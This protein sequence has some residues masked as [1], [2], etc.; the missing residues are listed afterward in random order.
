MNSSIKNKLVLSL[1]V[2]A[3]FAA[4]FCVY[5]NILTQTLVWDDHY[6]VKKFSLRFNSLESLFLPAD[7]KGAIM[8]FYRPVAGLSYL[9]DYSLWHENYIGYHLTNV[10]LHILNCLLLFTLCLRTNAPKK[11]AFGA[12]MLFALHPIHTESVSWISAR[13]DLIA[14]AFIFLAL[15]CHIEYLRGDK[16][17][18]IPASLFFAFAL[19]SKEI[20]L[21]GVIVFALYELLVEKKKLGILPYIF[22]GIVVITYFIMRHSYLV[23]SSVKLVFK[24][25][26]DMLVL[27]FAATGFYFYKFIFP[28]NLSIYIDSIPYI[29]IFFGLGGGLFIFTAILYMKEK[30]IYAFLMASFILTLMPSVAGSFTTT[31]SPPFAERYLYL[32]SAFLCVAAAMGIVRFMPY[33]KY[34]LGALLVIFGI[35]TFQR[36][37]VWRSEALLWRDAVQKTEHWYPQTQYSGILASEGNLDNSLNMFNDALEKALKDGASPRALSR[38]Y[39]NIGQVYVKKGETAASE[40]YFD[41]SLSLDKTNPIPFYNLAEIFMRKAQQPNEK[42]KDSYLKKAKAY[43]QKALENDSFLFEA[44]LGLGKVYFDLKDF[45]ESV[46]YYEKVLDMAPNTVYSSEAM[47]A[48]LRRELLTIK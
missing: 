15:I 2:L 1:V 17:A 11:I 48:L 12:A 4:V 37:D 27:F 21:G 33:S 30:K 7:L 10:M 28:F 3:I 36:N 41:K 23:D 31:L 5:S 42:S 44:Y 6:Y 45:A 40:K 32:P 47:G 34:V 29:P 16:K 9:L 25:Y 22:Y 26:L 13:L 43:Y 14:S 35:A 24:P 18:V 38:I 8:V 46:K 19:F 39:N 20:A